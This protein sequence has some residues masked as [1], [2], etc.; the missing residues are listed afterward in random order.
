VTSSGDPATI[1]IVT[2][3]TEPPRPPGRPRLHGLRQMR[4]N[5]RVL[6]TRRLDGRS[7]VAVAVKR[8]REDLERDLGGDPSRAQLAIIETAARTW[9]LLASVDDWL[10]RQPSIVHGKRRTLL[11]V[12]SQRLQLA[13]SLLRH[14][15]ALGL[16]RRARPA[17]SLAELLAMP[18]PKVDDD[19][20]A[21]ESH[22]T[23]SGNVTGSTTN[24]EDAGP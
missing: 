18:L 22:A 17:P 3:E 9:L 10:Q 1:G 16:E 23:D 12:V 11:P 5:I 8:F 14:L 24:A 13:D 19:I 21:A 2:D 20:G 4:D 7:R 6:T 15:T